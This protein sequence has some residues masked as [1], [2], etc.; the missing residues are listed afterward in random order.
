MSALRLFPDIEKASS[1][2]SADSDVVYLIFSMSISREPWQ[3]LMDFK[4]P[5]RIFAGNLHALAALYE[6]S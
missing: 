2:F 3:A 1:V 5:L 4:L 6:L